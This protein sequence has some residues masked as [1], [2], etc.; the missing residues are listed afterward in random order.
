MKATEKI[1]PI[2]CNMYLFLSTLTQ[3]MDD[4]FYNWNQGFYCVH[5]ISAR[6]QNRPSTG[7]FKY[8]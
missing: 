7:L 8:R 4:L 5:K 6:S 1:L 2:K 3:A